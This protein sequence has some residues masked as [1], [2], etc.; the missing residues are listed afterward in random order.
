MRSAVTTIVPLS[1]FFLKMIFH[2][3]QY[4]YELLQ[5]SNHAIKKKSKNVS[6]AVIL[7]LNIKHLSK[8]SK[9]YKQANENCRRISTQKLPSQQPNIQ[10][11]YFVGFWF[12]CSLTRYY[13]ACDP[14]LLVILLD[15]FIMALSCD[16]LVDASISLS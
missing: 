7:S 3:Q 9:K 1:L 8:Q 15:T 12:C 16:L 6:A 2:N 10:M 5:F 11:L 14:N 13:S 4:K